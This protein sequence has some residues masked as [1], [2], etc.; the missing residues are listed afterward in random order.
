MDK[1]AIR[2]IK[3]LHREKLSQTEVTNK[4]KIIN[5]RLIDFLKS[6]DYQSIAFYY[7]FKKEVGIWE[8]CHYCLNNNDTVLFPKI[9][10]PREMKYIQVESIEKQFEKNH[11]GILEPISNHYYQQKIDIVLVPGLAFDDNL[12]RIGY[13]KGYYDIFLGESKP[14][15]YT[16]GL[17]FACQKVKDIIL[18]ENHDIPLNK[19]ITEEIV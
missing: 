2:K 11:L 1:D 3:I 4:S 13:G 10:A 12:H 19:I 15:P 17:F 5:E 18:S 8:A 7:P 6:C 9:T 14:I 16:I